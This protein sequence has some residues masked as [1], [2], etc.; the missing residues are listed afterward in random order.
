MSSEILPSE[1]PKQES[2]QQ[3]IQ[4]QESPKQEPPKPPKPKRQP[5]FV[6]RLI[7]IIAFLVVLILI[8]LYLIFKFGLGGGGGSIL[9]GANGKGVVAT[10]KPEEKTEPEKVDVNKKETTTDE[11]DNNDNTKNDPTGNEIIQLRFEMIISFEPDPVE[12]DNVREFA[13]NIEKID[14]S[15]R[16]AAQ[17][18]KKS[19]VCE[20]M[21]D[22]AFEIE[23]EIRDW[24]SAF[25]LFDAKPSDSVVVPV[26]NVRMNPFPGEGV[27]RKIESIVLSIDEPKKISIM[28]SEN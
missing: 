28:R 5:T 2:S 19:I 22:F 17:K 20:N 6:Y 13:C 1:S 11:P 16:G 14:T 12:P 27:F 25:D 9:P 23:K 21:T 4:P 8:L 18:I 3:G 10:G 26:L 7:K 15:K 24:R